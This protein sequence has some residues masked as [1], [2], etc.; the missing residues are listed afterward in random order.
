LNNYLELDELWVPTQWQKDIS[1]KQGYPEDKIFVIPEGVDG[2]TFKP[3]SKPKKQGKFQFVI[4]GRWDY[5]KGIKESIEGFLKAFPDN[6]DVELLLNVENP[7]PVDGMK[8][9]KNV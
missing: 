3:T 9:Q 1:I 8:L 4:V 6:P 2:T 5:R 7:Y